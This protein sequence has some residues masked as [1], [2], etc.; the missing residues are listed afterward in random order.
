MPREPE[1]KDLLGIPD[2]LETVALI[3]MGYPE[4]KFGPPKRRSPEEV[5]SYNRWGNRR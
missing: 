5:T 4:G 3:P 2:H 1:I